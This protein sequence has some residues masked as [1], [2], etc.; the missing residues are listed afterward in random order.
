MHRDFF[1][2]ASSGAGCGAR[3]SRAEGSQGGLVHVFGV[4]ILNRDQPLFSVD[5]INAKNNLELGETKLE[6][7]NLAQIKP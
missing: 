3:T 4:A 1:S 7:G 2:R 5:L 6:C